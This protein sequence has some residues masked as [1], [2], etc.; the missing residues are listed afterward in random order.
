MR[1]RK[2]PSALEGEPEDITG[3]RLGVGT[4]D[5]YEARGHKDN[6][7]VRAQTGAYT[8][9]FLLP[10]LMMWVTL[11]RRSL[12]F[13]MRCTCTQDS[14]KLAALHVTPGALFQTLSQVTAAFL[15]SP[16]YH[17]NCSSGHV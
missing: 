10:T 8:C 13:I 3:P 1:A 4:K 2:E 7:N 14:E 15:R 5:L 12:P 11:Q 9:L 6:C 17:A 16:K